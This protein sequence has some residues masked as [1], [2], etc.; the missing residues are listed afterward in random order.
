VGFGSTDTVGT[1]RDSRCGSVAKNS[2]RHSGQVSLVV[3]VEG[4]EQGIVLVQGA[5]D[6]F[7][8]EQGRVDDVFGEGERFPG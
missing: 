8:T 5:G 7:V 1:R 4:H 2:R 3:D 6:S